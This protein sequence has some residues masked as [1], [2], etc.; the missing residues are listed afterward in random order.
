M[1]S[2]TQRSQGVPNPHHPAPDAGQFDRVP[3]LESGIPG[4]SPSG[5]PF[6]DSARSID[7]GGPDGGNEGQPVR[8]AFTVDDAVNA[9]GV[10][11]FQVLML[12]AV[13][14]AAAGKGAAVSTGAFVFP[15]VKCEW[16]L[17]D[18]Q[19][20]AI[21]ICNSFGKMVGSF[22]WGAFA[23]VAGRKVSLVVA[24]LGGILTSTIAANS[25]NG[26]WLAFFYFFVG[27]V[28][29]GQFSDL[30]YLLEFVP[31]ARRGQW[32]IGFGFFWSLGIMFNAAAAWGIMP[33]GGWQAVMMFANIPYVLALIL[34]PFV[35]ESPHYLV[36]AGYPDRARR[37]LA[38]AARINK[39]QLPNGE[40]L[41]VAGMRQGQ[42]RLP[43]RTKAAIKDIEAFFQEAKRVMGK[44]MRKVTVLV[45]V[46]WIASHT[47]YHIINLLNT[48]IHATHRCQDRVLNLSDSAFRDVLI[49]SSADTIGNIFPF[50]VIE[51]WGRK[52]SMLALASGVMLTLLPQM[53]VPNGLDPTWTLVV[54]RSL[55]HAANMVLA[56]YTPEVYPTNLR[57]FATGLGHTLSAFA[58]MLAPFAAQGLYH[59]FGIR[60][61]AAIAVVVAKIYM[62]SA[63]RLPADTTGKALK[64]VVD[65]GEAPPRTDKR[66]TLEMQPYSP[67]KGGPG[68]EDGDS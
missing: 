16:D 7:V 64:D 45:M 14:L 53:I 10:G 35:P 56:I 36:A 48:E 1:S 29:A 40:L 9:A 2:D 3:L 28:L 6:G 61:P 65:E 25:P 58:S 37:A 34:L 20:T 60:A 15:A 50:F 38:K 62:Y 5:P 12:A 55:L 46:A 57:A 18:Q 21:A 26:E 23:D 22:C 47:V 4:S 43:S 54:S 49:V 66:G 11:W 67:V 8:E 44:S 32:G 13:G 42:K 24:T 33:T 31:T 59:S 39:A 41:A 17:T 51:W 63:W 68:E 27:F 19:E 52:R 30:T